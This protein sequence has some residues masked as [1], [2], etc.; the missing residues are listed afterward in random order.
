MTFSISRS[1]TA[2]SSAAVMAPFSRLV[3]ASLSAAGRRKLPTWSARN[4]GLVRFIDPATTA[5]R[6]RAKARR[7]RRRQPQNDRRIVPPAEVGHIPSSVP[8][9]GAGSMPAPAAGAGGGEAEIALQQRAIG[10]KIGARPLVDHRAALE[11]RRP[12]GDAEY[13]LRVLLDQDRRH[14]FVADDAPQR[15]QQLLDQDRGESFQR[16]VEQYDARIQ[17]QGAADREH[18]LLAARKLVAE[19]AAAFLKPRKQLVDARL[20]PW[21]GPGH[22]G[23]I[24]LDGERFE[25]VALLRHPADAGKG[26][27]V[28]AQRRDVAAIE[29]DTAGEEARHAHDRIDQG[30]LAHAVA[31]EQSERL[32][33]GERERDVVEHDRLAVACAQP[34]DGQQFRHRATLPDTPPLRGDRAPPPAAHSRRTRRR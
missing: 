5:N 20:G 6:P 29:A 7:P 11:D 1:S 2:L 24:L 9:G 27:L 17:D 3:R 34:L 31:A 21:A 12:V 19:V 33:L 23:E 15:Q 8:G 13:L 30:G 28:R 10:G 22:G 26:A 32:S 4:G 16:L 25:D 14:A 18:L